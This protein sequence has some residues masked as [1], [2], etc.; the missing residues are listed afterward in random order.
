MKQLSKLEVNSVVSYIGVSDGYLGNF[1]YASHADFY[2][3]YCGLDI[4][5]YAYSGTTRERFIAILS[6]QDGRDQV[7]ILHGVIEKY[8]RCTPYVVVRAM[9]GSS[10]A[11]KPP[12]RCVS[13]AGSRWGFWSSP[14]C[15]ASMKSFGFL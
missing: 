6:S 13:W 11:D 2:P 1:S 9:H 15:L 4:D 5:P 7:K 14:R 3:S 12:H 10:L 8:L